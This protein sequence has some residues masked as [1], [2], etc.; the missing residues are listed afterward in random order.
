MPG[1]RIKPNYKI[2]LNFLV[3]LLHSIVTVHVCSG[4]LPFAPGSL[5]SLNWFPARPPKPSYN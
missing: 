2:G 4:M 5:N 1:K 3:V